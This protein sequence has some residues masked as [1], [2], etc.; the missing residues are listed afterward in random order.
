MLAGVEGVEVSVEL[1]QLIWKGVAA[2]CDPAA[3]LL[4]ISDVLQ[5]LPHASGI[6]VVV[7]S[8][9][10][11]SVLPPGFP[12]GQGHIC[13]FLKPSASTDLL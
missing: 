11:Q 13:P 1:T 7:V 5:A 2:D 6:C 12:D 4:E 10:S 9:Q 3:T 8:F